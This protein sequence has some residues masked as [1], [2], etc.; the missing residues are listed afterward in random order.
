MKKK[1]RLTRTSD[2]QRVQRHGRSHPH[3][4]VVV[5]VLETGEPGTRVAVTAGKR[6][7]GAVQRNRAKRLLR[8]AMREVYP[9]ITRGSDILLI[10]RKSLLAAPL[11]ELKNSL[12][13]LLHDADLIQNND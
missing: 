1:F 8:E 7:G 12:T 9:S 2:I 13:K 10:A 5:V 11:S 6:I 4:L 3:S